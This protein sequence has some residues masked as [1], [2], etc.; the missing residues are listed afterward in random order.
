MVYC[1]K[2]RWIS[3]GIISSI[4]TIIIQTQNTNSLKGQ[5]IEVDHSTP[6]PILPTTIYCSDTWSRRSTELSGIAYTMN[7]RKKEN[8]QSH[9]VRPRLLALARRPP[10]FHSRNILGGK[11]S[12]KNLGRRFISKEWER[13]KMKIQRRRVHPT[14]SCG[15]VSLDRVGGPLW[16]RPLSLLA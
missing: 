13:K 9:M 6:W 3:Q 2:W 4:L 11:M 5:M 7:K 1:D 14:R 12:P 15:S 16:K 10:Y 8:N